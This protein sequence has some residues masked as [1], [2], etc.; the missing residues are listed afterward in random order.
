MSINRLFIGDPLDGKRIIIECDRDTY[1]VAAEYGTSNMSVLN[2]CD[3]DST[4]IQTHLYIKT[5]LV[6]DITVMAHS[7]LSL[8][9]VAAMLVE[10]YKH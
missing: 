3:K 2:E 8:K 7:S 5:R 4:T 6:G 1:T 10:K 9:D